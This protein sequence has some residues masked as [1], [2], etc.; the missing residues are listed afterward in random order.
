MRQVEA[1]VAKRLQGKQT[2]Q[3]EMDKRSV[4]ADD[5]LVAEMRTVL[6]AEQF[7]SW[8]QDF[9]ARRDRHR[10]RKEH[11]KHGS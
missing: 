7:K 8:E 1:L 10:E 6:S 3:Q 5:E 9:R 4:A 11:N 2:M